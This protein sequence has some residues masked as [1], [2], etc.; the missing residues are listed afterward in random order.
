MKFYESLDG[1]V[2]ANSW[3]DDMRYDLRSVNDLL[4]IASQIEDPDFLKEMEG[5]LKEYMP[6]Q[7]PIKN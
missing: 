6:S 3:R 5:L 7:A 2:L 1:D 4:A